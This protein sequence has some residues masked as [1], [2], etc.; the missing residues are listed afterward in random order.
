MLLRASTDT[1]SRAAQRAREGNV[2]PG[3][4]VAANLFSLFLL[5]ACPSSSYFSLSSGKQKLKEQREGNF[6]KSLHESL[7][8]P[9]YRL[10]A[11]PLGFP[12]LHLFFGCE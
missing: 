10:N 9:P 3:E 7:K 6:R 11:K 8:L 1:L 12:L 2:F 4:T 5:R